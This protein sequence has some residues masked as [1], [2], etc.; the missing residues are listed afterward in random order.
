MQAGEDALEKALLSF[1]SGNPLDLL[2][3]IKR[4]QTEV[5]NQPWGLK[6]NLAPLAARLQIMIQINATRNAI[7][8]IL[9]NGSFRYGEG[10]REELRRHFDERLESAQTLILREPRGYEDGPEPKRVY[11]K[12]LDHLKEHPFSL[13]SQ[14]ELEEVREIIEQL[15]R[16]LKDIHARRYASHNRGMLD[17]KKTIR[18]AQRYQG[19]PVELFF[20]KKPPRKGKIVTL[21]DV[22]SSVWSAARFM[23]NVLYSLQ[24]CFTRVNS[25]VFVAGLSEVTDI[26][27]NHEINDA[28]ERVLR[29]ADIEYHASTDYGETFRQ[30]KAEHMDVLNKKTTLIIIGDGRTNYYNP[31]DRIL[32]EMR[33]KCR[34]VIW[35][36]PEPEA[37]WY[38]GDSEMF[39]YRPLCHELRPCRSL[40]QLISFVEELIL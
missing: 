2:S 25:F 17:V 13:L 40:N 1:L 30:F 36:N 5:E 6:M 39:S 38:S 8:A 9:A 34:R 28:I 3:E 7:A 23:L 14:Q 31:E 37:L 32:G 19:I 15:V 24:E 33:D 4:L 11:E 10:L 22:S 27:D 29:E 35:L 21:C 26:F 12:R 18:R 20:R 16:K